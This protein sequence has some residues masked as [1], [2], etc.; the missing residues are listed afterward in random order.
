MTADRSHPRDRQSHRPPW[1][2]LGN[3]GLWFRSLSLGVV[4]YMVTE[5]EYSRP[6]CALPG[7]RSGGCPRRDYL[8]NAPSGSHPH[9]TIRKWTQGDW[10]TCCGTARMWEN[11]ASKAGWVPAAI[12]TSAASSPGPGTRWAFPESWL[13]GAL[14]WHQD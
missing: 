13:C 2:L 11:Q 10:E 9:F 4:C 8:F 12:Y 14:C 5:S 6:L 1:T 7:S 3:K